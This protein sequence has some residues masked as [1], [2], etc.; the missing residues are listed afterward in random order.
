MHYA[1]FGRGPGSLVVLPGLNDGQRTVQGSGLLLSLIYRQFA[2]SHRVWVFSRRNQLE[3]DMTTRQMAADQ[4]EAMSKLGLRQAHVLGVSQGGMIGQWLA[5]DYPEYVDKLVLA[6]TVARSSATLHQV[7]GG[8][9][10]LA[11]QER[12]GDLA[13]DQMEKTF[14]E[15][16]LRRIR[17]FYWLLRRTGKPVSTER[18][19]TQARSCLRHD[20][21]GHL[22]RINS[23]TLIIGGDTDKVIG[24]AEVQHELAHGIRN[25]HLQLYPGLGHGA[26]AETKDFNRTIVDFLERNSSGG[27]ADSSQH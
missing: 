3:K 13:V 22:Y 24:S 19:L 26:F 25:S 15:N 17:P 5:I 16:Y 10:Q 27:P 7:I 14:T 8:W 11:L 21:Y 20:A 12:Y 6:M 4:G 2:R 18:F 23:P 9:I 1:A